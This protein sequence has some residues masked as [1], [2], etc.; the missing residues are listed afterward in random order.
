MASEAPPPTNNNPPISSHTSSLK[1]ALHPLALLSTSDYITRHTLRQTSGPIVGALLGTQEGRA[2][3]I[4][5]AYEVK[6]ANSEEGRVQVE[7]GQEDIV[8]D[9]EWFDKRLKLCK[10]APYGQPVYQGRRASSFSRAANVVGEGIKSRI[11]IPPWIS[12]DGT[13]QRHLLIFIQV[14]SM[15]LHTGAYRNIMNH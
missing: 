14:G 11:P 5:Q 4:E 7:D 15:C 9:E 6:V 10:S 3:A 8:L 13:Q 2:I 12:L 1:I